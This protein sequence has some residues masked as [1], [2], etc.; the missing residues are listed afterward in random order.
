MVVN[1]ARDVIVV[2]PGRMLI[3]LALFALV[4]AV[5]GGLVGF[6]RR[7]QDPAKRPTALLDVPS[8]LR[9]HAAWFAESQA[10]LVSGALT[11]LALGA[12]LMLASI[13]AIANASCATADEMC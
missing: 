2:A 7:T 10:A 12:L 13:W 3:T 9:G 11:G 5:E 8:T 6:L 4:G 1:F